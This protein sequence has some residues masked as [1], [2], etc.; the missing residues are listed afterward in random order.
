MGDVRV[1]SSRRGASP[2]P[3]RAISAATSAPAHPL[4]STIP[5]PPDQ[6]VPGRRPIGSQCSFDRS[7]SSP[8]TDSPPPCWLLLPSFIP[9]GSRDDAEGMA[10]FAGDDATLWAAAASDGGSDDPGHHMLFGAAASADPFIYL[11]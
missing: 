9:S 10:A 2:A 3:P 1:A 6:G 5:F 4:P 8:L 11:R 7:I